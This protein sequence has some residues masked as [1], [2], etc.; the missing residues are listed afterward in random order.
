LGTL[1]GFTTDKNGHGVFRGMV[2]LK[3]G[4]YSLNIDVVSAQGV[5]PDSGHREIG[6]FGCVEITVR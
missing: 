2:E 5:P 1:D 3:P 6:G 4:T